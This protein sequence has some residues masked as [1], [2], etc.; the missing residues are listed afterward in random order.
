[1][2]WRRLIAFCSP[3]AAVVTLAGALTAAAPPAAQAA[4]ASVSV[5]SSRVAES[6]ENTARTLD[7]PGG[8]YLVV[9]A[10]G[11]IEMVNAD[12]RTTWRYGSQSLYKDWDLTWE[13][14]SG[15]TPTPEVAWGTDPVNPLEFTGA[16]TGL[17]NDVSPAAAGYLDGNLDVAVAETVGS[18][19]TTESPCA[20]CNWPFDVPGS[21]L[22][23]GTFV[24]VF[25][26]RTGKMVYHEL[27]AGYVTQL[28]IDA[29]RLI[30]GNET[31][32][33]Q[34]ESND[35]GAW[36]SFS[37][38]TAL[39]VSDNGAAHQAWTYSTKAEW[40]RLLDL[41]V[42]RAG[43]ALAWS[44][45]PEGLG[46]PG[47]AD[48]HVL[49]F[50]PS[51]GAVDWKVSTAGYP[52]L[53]AADD[54]GGELAVVDLT[55]PR[56]S[57]RY[58]L[59]GLR[60]SNG[61]VAVTVPISGA[62][63]LSLAV[64]GDGWAVGAVNVTAD[65][66]GYVGSSGRV[67][68]VDAATGKVAWSRTLA[69]TDEGVPLPGGLVVTRAKVVAGSWVGAIS[70]TAAQP[71]SE[72]DSLTAYDYR[73]GD[74]AW[75]ES[76]DT[77]DPLSLS[78]VA[79]GPGLVRAVNSSQDTVTYSATGATQAGTGSGPGDFIT[80]VDVDGTFVAGN[81]DGDVYA[82]AGSE[83]SSVLWRAH[84]PGPVHKI[85]SDTLNGRQILIAAATSAVAVLDARTGQVLSI[86]QTTNT[87]AYT[88]TAIS[89][90]GV[91][92][93]VVPGSSLTAY[94]LTTGKQLW[95]YAAPSG[96]SFSDAAYADGVVAAEYSST[97]PFGGQ[98][99][100]IGA[101]GLDAST[102]GVTWSNTADPSVVRNGDLWNGA[103]TSQYI[104]GAD[105]A[106]VALAWEDTSGDGQV[107]VRDIATGRLLYS[108]TSA[109]LNYFTQFLASSS[110]GLIAVSQTGSALITATGA[111]STGAGSGLTAALAG[112]DLVT[113]DANV[114][115]YGT[116]IFTDSS[117][118]DLAADETYYTGTV[119]SLGGD[120]VAAMSPD[121]MAYEIV[122]AEA[123][124]YSYAPFTPYPHGLEVLTLSASSSSSA[125]N[126][127]RAPSTEALPL[128]SRSK[129]I[130]ADMRPVGQ[131]GSTTPTTEQSRSGS[132]QPMLSRPDVKHTEDT[133]SASALPAGYS[134][135]QMTAYLD[136]KGDGKGE[137]IAIVDAYDDPD[138]VSDAETFSQEYGLPGVCG[139]GG[140]AGDCF[141]L[142]VK[143]E[144]AS[145]GS[146]ADWALET[147]LDV[148]WAHTIAP[149]AT[150]ELVEASNSTL[151]ALFS[152]VRTA[153]ASRPAAVSM[154]WGTY[155]EFSEENYYDHFCETSTTVCVVSAGDYGHPGGYPA[156][157]PSVISIG[158][159]TLNLASDGSLSSE[160]TWSDSGGGQS[161]V[162]P[163]P[164]YQR[165][166][167][168]TG[169]RD[170][171]D[172]SF[173]ANLSTGVAIY[174]SVP[175]YGQS[176][177]FVVGG[178]SVG[179][180]S[181]SA[182]LTDAD[183]LRAADGKT[184]LTAADD[185][186][187]RALY[188]LSSSVLAPITTG[189]DN[190]FCPVGCSPTAGYDQITGLGSPRSGI[191]TA[192]TAAK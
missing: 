131:V 128:P 152:A 116:D 99:S 166:V 26:A 58:T 139:A 178:T 41:T 64:S 15:F 174:D 121:E 183:Q 60:Y 123:G 154:S 113:S 27:V 132:A 102:G 84:L 98:A 141:N 142:D 46:E 97:A 3:L 5:T 192:L 55:D 177:W 179:A 86:I 45:T 105:G 13:D 175:Y 57:L 43:L 21:S 107:D 136:L 73:S 67:A 124:L 70:P 133:A 158:G 17:V 75:S 93:V 147:S 145:A 83:L 144:N 62:L 96:A 106:G 160:Q 1:M 170:M 14:D 12:G 68:L 16:G 71:E 190:G 66:G 176:G 29:N 120:R 77:G 80:G 9:H 153:V 146:D 85:V 10:L 135:A 25:N 19:M 69:E 51:T 49:L 20:N 78:A 112:G 188:S 38:V 53:T 81:A 44:D 59:T 18:N 172:V 182:I 6:A 90:G 159:T 168:S 39:S 76:G 171:P 109:N 149:E 187:Q 7:V 24:S 167:Q 89:V 108:D 92:A 118:T 23:L 138:I 54:Q 33:P 184:A 186:A 63:P 61:S 34:N 161:W 191:D 110:L 8:G 148:E 104:P 165:G 94:A 125:S 2:R 122:S 140:T 114:A 28:A 52:V 189:S 162:E 31:G 150:I 173:D 157:N 37:S 129:T 30:V 137:T 111:E 56:E 72:L 130:P 185:D 11:A 164:A 151:A 82:F 169:D 47:P 127:V 117:A 181:W 134:P 50:N 115:V 74:V 42:T 163:E 155:G 65:N 91:P 180:P 35:I 103:F 100:E 87:Y 143:Q 119:V 36:R 101:V 88:V 126:G 32:D 79:R 95:S 156:Y 4:A 22:H 48:G 40:G